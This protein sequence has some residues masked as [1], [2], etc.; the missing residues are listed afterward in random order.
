MFITQD[1]VVREF[2]YP[3]RV[4]PIFARL[5][6]SAT[7]THIIMHIHTPYRSTEVYDSVRDG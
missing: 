7:G 6:M 2:R 1:G 5:M 4:Y 3:F